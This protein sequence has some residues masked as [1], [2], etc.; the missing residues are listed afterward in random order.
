MYILGS[1]SSGV[2]STNALVLVIVTSNPS[3][4]DNGLVFLTSGDRISSRCI[5]E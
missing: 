2:T 5:M 4:I 1:E 3:I